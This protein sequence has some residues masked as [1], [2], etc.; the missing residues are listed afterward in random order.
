MRI[1]DWSS[2]VCSSDLIVKGFQLSKGKYV[3]L[4]EEE[5]EGVKLESRRTL[6]LVQFVDIDAID[7]LY[8]TKPYYVVPA[9]ELAEE[10]YIIL[11]EALKRTKKVGLGQLTLRGQ[12]QLVAL[13]PFGRGLVLEVL[14]YA[15]EVTKAATHFRALGH[16]KTDPAPPQP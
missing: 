8:Y 6:E 5:I 9:D 11:R 12:E 14:R 3:L 15:A 13:R 1:S 16:S 10:A 7:V 2:D 4:D